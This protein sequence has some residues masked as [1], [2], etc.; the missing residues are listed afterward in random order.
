VADDRYEVTVDELDED[1]CWRLLERTGFGRVGFVRDGAPMV[2]PVNCAV[3]DGRVVFRTADD[4]MLAALGDGSLVA[5]ESDHSDRISESGWSVLVRGRMWDVT[6]T[7]EAAT[8][9]E[10]KVRTWAPGARDRWMMIVPEEIT[11]RSIHRH[12]ILSGGHRATSTS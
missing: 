5:F 12:R 1:D 8:W 11:G 4:A 7:L 10:L 3:T 6:D 2:L 9:D